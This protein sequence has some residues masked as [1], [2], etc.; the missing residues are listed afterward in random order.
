MKALSILSNYTQASVNM[1]A[2]KPSHRLSEHISLYLYWL[3]RKQLLYNIRPSKL[4]IL[5]LFLLSKDDEG[6]EVNLSFR[7]R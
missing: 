3:D 7:R 1:L 4:L 2:Q 6:K 5:I